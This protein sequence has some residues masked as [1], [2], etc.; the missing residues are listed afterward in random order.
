MMPGNLAFNRSLSGT[1]CS[2]E[3]C[4][5]NSGQW[6]RKVQDHLSTARYW[7]EAPIDLRVKWTGQNDGQAHPQ[8]FLANGDCT[9][10]WA[11]VIKKLPDNALL[12]C[13]SWFGL[14]G[15]MVR[16]CKFI[17]RHLCSR[18]WNGR[19]AIIGLVRANQHVVQSGQSWRQG[20]VRFELD[21]DIQFFWCFLV[22]FSYSWSLAH[23]LDYVTAIMWVPLANCVRFAAGWGHDLHAAMEQHSEEIR[24]DSVRM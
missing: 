12:P 20:P 1:I 8:A 13:R 10:T 23:K 5:A 11:K 21:L 6:P 18:W 2:S 14:N 24:G 16:E 4:R 17:L 22:L 15:W 7:R 3:R 19:R 9:W